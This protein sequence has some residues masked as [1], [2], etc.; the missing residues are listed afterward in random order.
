M[1]ISVDLILD[2][3]DA[4]A[5]VPGLYMDPD[6]LLE[7]A[8]GLALAFPAEADFM[9]ACQS[10]CR[11]LEQLIAQAVTP[12][13]L[14]YGFEGWKSFH[15]Q[16]HVGQGVRASCRIIYRNHLDGI[17]VKGFGHRWVPEDIYERM[18]ATRATRGGNDER[19]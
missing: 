3:A 13:S 16:H 2:A 19:A 10:T 9:M 14:K 17:E 4:I 1:A 11:A 7:D 8:F 6:A 18:S 12:S 15:Y 5:A